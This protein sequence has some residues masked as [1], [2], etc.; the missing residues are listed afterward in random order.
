MNRL[1]PEILAIIIKMAIDGVADIDELL[2]FFIWRR[3]CK[4]WLDVIDDIK[5]PK[6]VNYF[7]L[8]KFSAFVGKKID[9]LCA[10][11]S[12]LAHENECCSNEIFRL[13]LFSK[14]LEMNRISIGYLC[15]VFGEMRGM[16]PFSLKHQT[17]QDVGLYKDAD[18]IVFVK[19][20]YANQKSDEHLEEFDFWPFFRRIFEQE[21]ELRN[22]LI[23]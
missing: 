18:N 17:Y 1:P 4:Q 21:T 7:I 6:I 3:V 10:D 20:F 8:W 11:R 22:Q 16:I 19:V 5:L 14:L 13:E 9:E 12:K 15:E 23:M 2:V